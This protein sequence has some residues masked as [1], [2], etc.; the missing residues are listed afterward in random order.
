M[1]VR[2][3]GSHCGSYEKQLVFSV[4]KRKVVEG[5]CVNVWMGVTVDLMR[6]SLYSTLEKEEL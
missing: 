3:D 2:V 5:E 1:C 6:S 4:R